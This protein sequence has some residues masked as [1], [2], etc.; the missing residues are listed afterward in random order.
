ME[1][2][3]H[4]FSRPREVDH[5]REWSVQVKIK[6]VG[7]SFNFKYQ[8]DGGAFATTFLDGYK[9]AQITL[10]EKPW[11]PEWSKST[12]KEDLEDLELQFRSN[13]VG[14]SS[15]RCLYPQT[16]VLDCRRL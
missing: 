8:V 6:C 16:S 11:M 13:S 2:R 10:N 15:S 5:L 4:I 9:Q 1:S 14:T 7:D 3:A 12:V